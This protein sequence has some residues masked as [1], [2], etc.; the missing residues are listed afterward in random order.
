MPKRKKQVD[1]KKARDIPAEEMDR[2][3]ADLPV[4]ESVPGDVPAEEVEP[5]VDEAAQLKDRLLRLQADFDNYRKRMD[6]ERREWAAYAGEQVVRELL[7]V[8]DN[9]E[10]GL[11]SVDAADSVKDGFALI[12]QQLLTVLDKAGV[13]PVADPVGQLFDPAIH[14]AIA[15]VPSPDVPEGHVMAQT[16]RG[17]QMTDRLL[18]PA[19]VVVSSGSGQT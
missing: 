6:R 18:R 12:Y 3:A 2:D 14:E 1:E 16:R 15:H 19:Q 11:E 9:F 4:E 7:P 13:T 10:R 17:Y 8:L 5:V